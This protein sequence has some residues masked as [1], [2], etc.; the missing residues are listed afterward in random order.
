MTNYAQKL[1]FIA[2]SMIIHYSQETCYDVDCH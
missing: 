2:L 1:A